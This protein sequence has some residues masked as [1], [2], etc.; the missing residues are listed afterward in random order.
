MVMSLGGN[1]NSEF[2]TTEQLV[3]EDAVSIMVEF[4]DLRHKQALE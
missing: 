4:A 2:R 1:P 3:S